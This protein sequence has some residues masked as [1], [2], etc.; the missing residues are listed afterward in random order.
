MKSIKEVMII[1]DDSTLIFLA[2]KFIQIIGMVEKTTAFEDGKTAYQALLDRE[3][4]GQPYP[5]IILLDITMQDWDAWTTL[6]EFKKAGILNKL[7]IY[8]LTSSSSK[9]DRRL[10]KTFNL[11]DQYIEKPISPE[12]LRA[13]FESHLGA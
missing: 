12:L 3:K 10:A 5:D 4:H 1:D 2:E 11:E 6:N 8:I 13:I 7:D 9:E